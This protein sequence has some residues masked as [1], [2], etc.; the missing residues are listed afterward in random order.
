MHGSN[1]T[2]AMYAIGLVGKE[3]NRARRLC[4]LPEEAASRMTTNNACSVGEIARAQAVEQ[5]PAGGPSH[6]GRSSLTGR[7]VPK[8]SVTPSRCGLPIKG[9]GGLRPGRARPRNQ[10]YVR[11]GLR[12]TNTSRHSDP[13]FVLSHGD[14]D[15]FAGR[16]SH[17]LVPPTTVSR[18]SRCCPPR[19]SSLLGATPPG[20]HCRSLVG[21]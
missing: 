16:G 11:S 9:A 20:H 4:S 10:T 8:H 12:G 6:R 21:I 3:A 5:R 1:M 13:A 17:R 18:R 15:A 2:S 19:P 14:R 7:T